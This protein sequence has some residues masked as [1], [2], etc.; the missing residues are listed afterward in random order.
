MK[1]FL[2]TLLQIVIINVLSAVSAYA[3]YI[4]LLAAGVI[5]YYE[6]AEPMENIS[7]D[8]T[9]AVSFIGFLIIYSA[10]VVRF[11]KS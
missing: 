11:K 5:H 3:V 2:R 7:C 8:I 1:S 6:L 9:L 10:A 4:F